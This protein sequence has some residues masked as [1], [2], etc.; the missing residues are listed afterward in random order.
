MVVNMAKVKILFQG[1][2]ISPLWTT[3][4]ATAS[5][6][7]TVENNLN[8]A[9]IFHLGYVPCPLQL[10]FQQHGLNT[11]DLCLFKDSNIRLQQKM[12]VGP[13]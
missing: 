12:P 11:G 2:L 10:R 7:F 8:E 4:L 1:I 3:S 5:G 9:V 6:E 13:G